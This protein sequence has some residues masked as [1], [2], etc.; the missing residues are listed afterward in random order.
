[1]NMH[2]REVPEWGGRAVSRP[3]NGEPTQ[4]IEPVS[5]APIDTGKLLLG[6]ASEPALTR[7]VTTAVAAVLGMAVAWGLPLTQLQQDSTI[8][9]IAVLAPFIAGWWIRRKVNSP[10]TVRAAL[11]A[12]ARR[13]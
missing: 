6:D 4:P 3:D 12:A 7:G 1:M 11:A 2:E 5:P 10:K 8:T 9:A 13:R